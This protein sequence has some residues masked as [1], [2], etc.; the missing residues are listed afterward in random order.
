MLCAHPHKLTQIFPHFPAQLVLKVLD[1]LEDQ[2]ALCTSIEMV[3][4]D[5][6]AAHVAS[7]LH[8]RDPVSP[9]GR[10]KEMQK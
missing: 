4:L 6:G 1:F 3:A 7:M 2:R 10:G 9:R 5:H 8:I